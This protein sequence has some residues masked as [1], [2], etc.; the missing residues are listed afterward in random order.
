MKLMIDN[1]LDRIREDLMTS[2]DVR[3]LRMTLSES[4]VQQELDDFLSVWDLEVEGASKALLMSYFMKAHPDLQYPAYVGPRLRGLLEYYRFHNIKLIA[5]FKRI[6]SKL[7]EAGIE[8]TIFKGGAMKHLR[9]NLSRAMS[10]ID[11]IVADSDYEKAGKVIADMGYYISWDEHSFDVHTEKD[12]EGIL[13]VHKFIPMLTGHE[14]YIMD[15]VN[16]RSKDAVLFGVPGKI[17]CEEDMVFSLLVN[18][19]R[20]IMNNTSKAGI[21][22]T[23]IDVKYL[24]DSRPDFDWNIVSENARKA[25]AEKIMAFAVR[26]MDNVVPGLVKNPA[27]VSEDQIQEIATLVKYRRYLLCPLQE[28]SHQ[29]GVSTVLANPR[30]IPDFIKVRP[31][32]TFLKL[33]RKCPSIAGMILSMHETV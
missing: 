7:R 8:V 31:R 24:L 27:P 15:E 3:L 21:L 16:A 26:F 6:V 10:D 12:G 19:S 30:L 1:L 17:L 4:P 18:L 11:V 28:R 33:F 2:Q 14:T 13:D 25:G 32:Y 20:N 9:P 29:L 5:Q 22:Y 23:F